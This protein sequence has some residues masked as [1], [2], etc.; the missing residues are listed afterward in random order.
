MNRNKNYLGEVKLGSE[1][2]TNLLITA[3]DE[4]RMQ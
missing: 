4:A 3:G 2:E 1:S